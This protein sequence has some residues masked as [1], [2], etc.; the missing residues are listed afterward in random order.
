MSPS[1]ISDVIRGVKRPGPELLLALRNSLGVSIDWLLTGQGSMTGGTGIRYELFQ[2]IRIHVAVAKAAVL[3]GDAT[4]KA[5]LSLI[6]EGNLGVGE[7]T[8]SFRRLLDDIVPVDGDLDLIV[9]LYN[10]HQWA[11]DPVTQRRNLVAAAV[12]HFETRKPF[13]RLSALV[14]DA[15]SRTAQQV[16]SGKGHRIAAGNYIEQRGRKK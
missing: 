12:A 7:G 10:G 15:P 13:D 6:Q 5:L 14:G 3:G 4:A 1:F 11:P 16:I 9:Q 2:A 8:E